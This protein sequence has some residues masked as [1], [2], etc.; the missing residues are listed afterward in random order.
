MTSY[1]KDPTPSYPPK[2][3][4]YQLGKQ[5]GY[6][7]SKYVPEH[8]EPHTEPE[9]EHH[10]GPPK[11]ECCGLPGKTQCRIEPVE[12]K[13]CLERCCFEITKCYQPPCRPRGK[14]PVTKEYQPEYG[15][16]PEYAEILGK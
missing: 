6:D 7:G 15:R 9:P 2:P 16:K 12:V 4:Q 14:R 13:D 11:V 3:R 5:P 10:C 1:S 8:P